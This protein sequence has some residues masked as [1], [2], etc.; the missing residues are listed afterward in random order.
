MSSTLPSP[1]QPTDL[2][3]FE[4]AIFC[5]RS[6]EA[7][8]ITSLF[9]EHWDIRAYGKAAGDTNTYSIGAMSGYNVVLVH[10]PNIGKVTAATAAAVLCTSFRAI[11]LALVVGT[12]GGVPSGQSS[13]DDIHLGDVV[14]SDGIIQYDFGRKFPHKFIRKDHVRDNLPRPS[15]LVRT[16]LAK[17]RMDQIR[18][19]LGEKALEYL[20]LFKPTYWH[21]HY[22]PS[23][24]L[25]CNSGI[26]EICDAALKLSCQYLGCDKQELV[27][28]ARSI[29]LSSTPA[30]HFGLVASGDSV[31]KSGEERDRAAEEDE[32]IAF[33]ME[34]AG[35]WEVF[36]NCLIIKGV[37]NYADSHKSKRWH[38]YAA[39]T[40]AATTKA[41]LENWIT[42][43]EYPS[44]LAYP[45]HSTPTATRTV[46]S[47][48]ARKGAIFKMLNASPYLDRKEKNPDQVPG[49]CEWFVNHQS[50]RRWRE[51]PS[52]SML[53]V[54]A[55]PGCGRSVL[56]KHLVDFE[57]PST[58]SR[59]TCYFFFKND[60]EDQRSARS[61]LCC[62]LHQLF[63]QKGALLSDNVIERF[64]TDGEHLTKFYGTRNNLNLNFLLTSRPY[65]NIRRGFQPLQIP[66]LPVIH[67]S[68]ESEVEMENLP[69]GSMLEHAEEQFLLQ[70]LLRVPNRTYI[71]AHLT[72]D[73][74]HDI[75]IDKTAIY[76][77]TSQLPQ[78]IDEAYERILAKNRDHKKAKRLL[79]IVVAVA[80]PLT[81]PEMQL[82]LGLRESHGLNKELNFQLEECFC[83]PRKNFWFKMAPQIVKRV[84]LISSNGNPRCRHKSLIESLRKT[85]FGTSFSLSLKPM[86][87]TTTFATRI[88]PNTLATTTSLSILLRTRQ[89]TFEYHV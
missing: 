66:G 64:E 77:A 69:E 9:D 62:I 30:I 83:E 11:N 25:V 67:L 65:G 74:I 3:D 40:A 72:L 56:A 39:A 60:F 80:R 17:L 18:S 45:H 84:T 21:K 61:A 24:C 89:L 23:E 4:I 75:D 51:S 59:T 43:T 37:C 63:K 58:R 12:C 36:P 57:L 78:T 22:K 16:F 7:G 87:L 5:A 38:A 81:L 54:S 79:H 31:M 85:A 33:E 29:S 86:F 42:E 71:W 88:W 49:T 70:G 55:D 41:V 47:D 1:S 10:L 53:W 34:G 13:N 27:R 19:Q 52:S 68:G 76:K 82:A 15:T 73:L 26:A 8:A 50:F 20:R 28:R 14:V 35:I 2:H 44:R 32:V 6:L 46:L 48:P